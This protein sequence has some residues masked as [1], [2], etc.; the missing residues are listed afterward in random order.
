[1]E[2]PI[3]ASP[4]NQIPEEESNIHHIACCSDIEYLLCC[5]FEDIDCIEKPIG[6]NDQ[7]CVVCY[8]L[9]NSDFCPKYGSC[10]VENGEELP[11]A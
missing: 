6:P 1:M 3:T 8:E 5:G 10:V 2:L 7:K 4:T 11:E 9:K